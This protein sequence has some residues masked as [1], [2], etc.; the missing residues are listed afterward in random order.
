MSSLINGFPYGPFH[1][2]PVKTNVYAP[3][4]RTDARVAYTLDLVTILEALLPEGIDGGISTTPLSYKAWLPA[5]DRSDW[6]LIASNLV[7]VAERLVRVARGD[8]TAHSCRCRAEY[9][10]HARDERGGGGFFCNSLLADC[11]F[12]ARETNRPGRG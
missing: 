12:L 9:R 10:L 8:R 2:E 3:D 4:W 6:E 1:D 11:R 7:R 5:P